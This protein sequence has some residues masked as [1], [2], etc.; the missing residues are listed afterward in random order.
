[1][2]AE[3]SP[4]HPNKSYLRPYYRVCLCTSQGAKQNFQNNE[5]TDGIFT[6]AAMSIAAAAE[7]YKVTLFQES[8]VNG[9]R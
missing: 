5:E 2:R 9:S 8:I 4:R 1:L 3:F 6:V 7:S